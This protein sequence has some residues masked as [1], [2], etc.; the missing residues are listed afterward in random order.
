MCYA[1]IL[2]LDRPV[3]YLFFVKF[4]RKTVTTPRKQGRP[5][6]EE[7]Y[8]LVLNAASHLFLHDGFSKTSMDT[9]AK[10]SGVSKQTVYSHFDSK[11]A[12]FQAAITSKCRSYQLDAEQLI[13]ITDGTLSLYEGLKKVGAQFVRLI[14]DQEAVAMFRVIIAEAVNNTHV[15]KLFYEAGPQASV[16][17]LKDVVEQCGAGKLT[18]EQAYELALDFCALLK[19]E[20]H[21]MMLCGIR[22][23]MTE[24]EIDLHVSKAAKKTCLLFDYYLQ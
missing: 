13:D 11:D 16:I 17:T 18:S 24:G 10:A 15:A 14:Q 3:W 1:S 6:S 2:I 21:T 12:L 9:V 4:V 23:P 5:K 20:L 19:S 22:K 7:K 8:L